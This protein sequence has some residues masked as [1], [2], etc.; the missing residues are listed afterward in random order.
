MT[1][2]F[3]PSLIPTLAA[4]I[5]IAATASLGNW[6]RGRADE[7]RA[8]Q[9][10]LEARQALPPE[11]VRGVES[12]VDPLTYRRV[13]VRG[14]FEPQRQIFLDNKS[15]ENR[16]GVHLLTPFRIEGSG[17]LMLVNRGW[18]PRP[19]T[20]P[21]MP[22]VAAPVGVT[23]LSGLAVP[24]I[25][26]FVELADNTAQGALWQ[27]VTIDRATTHL[28]EP[29]FP[30]ILLANATAPGFAAVSERP[31]AGIEKHQGYAFQWYA[32]ATLVAI[33]WVALNFRNVEST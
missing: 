30:L 17:R 22:D 23:E 31:D 26:R 4:G 21:N 18:L 11:V 2:K 29:V 20:Y 33:L 25:R 16:V 15:L 3:R 10:Q 12:P 24:P 1:R 27:N 7:K 19:R 13:V 8:V 9:Q 14:Q 5:A 32:L 6:Q 28:G